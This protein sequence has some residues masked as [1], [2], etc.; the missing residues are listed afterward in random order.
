[1]CLPVSVHGVAATRRGETVIAS[2]CTNKVTSVAFSAAGDGLA[3][4]SPDK[5]VPEWDGNTGQLLHTFKNIGW[6][7]SAAF[8]SDGFF[9]E[10]NSKLMLPPP[11][12]PLS[13]LLP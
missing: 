2:D 11:A 3:S 5:A 6:I 12:Q 13:I 9:I 1:M 7:E 4:A 8:S 10:T